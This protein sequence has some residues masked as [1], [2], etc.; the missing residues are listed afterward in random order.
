MALL[1]R[2]RRGGYPSRAYP[3]YMATAASH[4]LRPDRPLTGRFVRVQ[5]LE[6]RHREGLRAAGAED[7]LDF[8]Y[9]AYPGDFDRWFDDALGSAVEVP[10]AVI[11]NGSEAGSTRYLNFEASHKR[12]EIGWTWLRPSVWGT[13][14]NV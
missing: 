5:P 9:M 12:V 14:A 2:G 4:T 13:G 6:E 3:L 1:G 7:P 10:F 11:W 8:R